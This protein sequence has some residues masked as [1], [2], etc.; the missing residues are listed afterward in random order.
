M[1]I[2]IHIYIHVYYTCVYIYMY[3]CIYMYI[4]SA[5]M[6]TR[7]GR[8]QYVKPGIPSY[9]T[10]IYTD[11]MHMYIFVCVC[12]CM[13]VCMCVCVCVSQVYLPLNTS[14]ARKYLP[15]LA[16]E[17][18][19]PITR[20]NLRDMFRIQPRRLSLEYGSHRRRRLKRIFALRISQ[21][22]VFPAPPQPHQPIAS[23]RH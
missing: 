20:R 3:I 11:I 9:Y 5:S 21:L 6:C 13:H 1:Y 19:V 16:G 14:S 7:C 22:P 12:V 10:H 17:G 8:R 4:Y 15:I 18:G 2:C 23:E